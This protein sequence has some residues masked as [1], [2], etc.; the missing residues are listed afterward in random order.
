MCNVCNK[1][2]V[3]QHDLK[4]H[5]KI[6]MGVKDYVCLCGS[7]FARMDALTRHRQ[8]G[9]CRGGFPGA[10]RSE[11]KRGRPKK[12]RP[13]L[14]ARVSKANAQRAR[15]TAHRRDDSDDFSSGVSAASSPGSAAS[16]EPLL[17]GTEFASLDDAG[18]SP[19][20][21]G[22]SAADLALPQVTSSMEA[23]SLDGPTA[24]GASTM[25]GSTAAD[26]AGDTSFDMSGLLSAEPDVAAAAAAAMQRS[27]S[28]DSAD[29]YSTIFDSP[30]WEAHGGAAADA[31]PAPAALCFEYAPFF[32]G[33][34][35][36]SC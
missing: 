6:H 25:S 2:F 8:R 22:S 10:V 1:R 13:E 33:P 35:W 24:L 21:D 3:R 18:A 26:L 12:H 7:T 15:N 9:M 20:A 34:A 17:H 36:P 32:P 19:R 27:S 14:D 4:R 5:A 30:V 11:K 23:A 31:G 29:S 16:P 28:G